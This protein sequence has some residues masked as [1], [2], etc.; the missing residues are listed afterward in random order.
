[1]ERLSMSVCPKT[2]ITVPECSCPDCIAG[3]IRQY[4]PALLEADPL[5]EIRVTKLDAQPTKGTRRTHD[6]V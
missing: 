3:Q 4:Q 5:G 2:G 6:I 1:M